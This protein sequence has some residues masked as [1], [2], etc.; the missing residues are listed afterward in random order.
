M[1]YFLKGEN[2]KNYFLNKFNILFNLPFIIYTVIIIL[3]YLSVGAG[4]IV[5]NKS[6][7]L[8]ILLFVTGI[9]LSLNRK[10]SK[11]VGFILLITLFISTI[12]I[13]YYDYFK[14]ITTIFGIIFIIYYL[15]IYFFNKR[16]LKGKNKE[17]RL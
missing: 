15:I 2:M 10:I 16:I 17:G 11:I 6:L 12:I 14:W 4:A 8:I 9:C 3:T 13:G 5:I 7:L 1:K